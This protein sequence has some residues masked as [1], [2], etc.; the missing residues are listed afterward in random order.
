LAISRASRSKRRRDE[1][2]SCDRQMD[3]FDSD[4]AIQARLIRPIHGR[5]AALTDFFEDFVRT[6]PRPDH[7]RILSLL[8]RTSILTQTQVQ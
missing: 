6:E 1:R 4:I 7:R 5:H 3:D 2:I 8:Q